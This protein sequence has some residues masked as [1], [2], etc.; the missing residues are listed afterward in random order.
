MRPRSLIDLRMTAAANVLI[1]FGFLSFEAAPYSSVRE[2]LLIVLRTQPA[3]FRTCL[4]GPV[5]FAN[6]TL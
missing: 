4:N 2:S 6:L 3:H 5:T 1:M